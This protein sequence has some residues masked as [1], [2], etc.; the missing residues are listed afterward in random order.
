MNLIVGVQVMAN[1]IFITSKYMPSPDANG[2]CV[3]QIIK[4]LQREGHHLICICTQ[5]GTQRKYEVCEGV[6]IYRVE[7]PFYANQLEKQRYSIKKNLYMQVL[8]FL[9]RIRSFILLPIFPN[10]E[11]CR[12]RKIYRLVES[13]IK[14]KPIHCVIGV[15]R[16]FEGVAVALKIK[17]IYPDII[18][19]GYYLDIMKGATISKLFPQRMYFKLCDK[20]ELKIYNSLDFV[21]MAEA[22]KKIYKFPYFKKVEKK[23]RYINFPVFRDIGEETHQKIAFDEEYYN[24]VYAGYLDIN[25]RNP[26]F[27]FN[28]IKI[29]CTKGYKIRLHL[30]GKNNCNDLINHYCRDNPDIFHYYGTVDSNKA[31]SAILSADA[32]LNISNKTDNIV[33]SKVFELCSSCKPI[34]NVVTN[35]ND[36]SLQYFALYPSV[37][38]INEY[39]ENTEKEAKKLISFLADNKNCDICFDEIE[40]LYYSSTP[41]ATTS[42]INEYL[43]KESNI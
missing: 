34:I 25:Y 19:G 39:N 30:Y 20:R 1:I 29:V 28:V 7:K 27:F 37:C 10:T 41:I 15:F 22:G 21:L 26:A 11:P 31:K 23:I 36:A 13:I 3:A 42:I 32:V 8:T 12:A 6:E 35:P 4:Q 14:E 43:N 24:I 38:F 5:E 40:P 2:I 17:K 33:P 9:R 16:P 18:C